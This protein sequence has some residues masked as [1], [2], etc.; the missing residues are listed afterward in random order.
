MVLGVESA[1]VVW[2]N[3]EEDESPIASPR[4][5]NFSILAVPR[6]LA[7]QPG[8]VLVQDPVARNRAL[9]PVF[10]PPQYLPDFFVDRARA[11]VSDRN[12]FAL[13]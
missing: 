10:D 13:H 9:V 2:A 8:S 5:D 1:R 6:D 3:P 7:A 12:H 11:Q 4:R